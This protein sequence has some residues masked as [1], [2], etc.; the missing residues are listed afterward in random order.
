MCV[1]GSHICIYVYMIINF[2][3]VCAAVCV[4]MYLRKCV[5]LKKIVIFN[6]RAD[7]Q[8][9]ADDDLIFEDFA[10]LRLQNQ[11]SESIDA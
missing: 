11:L 4:C 6:F 9:I 10:R 7:T 5:I 2:I 1:Y 8:N 3:C